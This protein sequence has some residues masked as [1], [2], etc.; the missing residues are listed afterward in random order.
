MNFRSESSGVEIYKKPCAV[1]KTFAI[2]IAH[3]IQKLTEKTI[4]RANK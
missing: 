4:N 3:R 2:A 1:L